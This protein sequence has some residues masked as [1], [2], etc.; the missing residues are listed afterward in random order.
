MPPLDSYLKSCNARL[1]HIV[2]AKYFNLVLYS[3]KDARVMPNDPISMVLFAIPYQTYDINSI[4]NGISK[5][6]NDTELEEALVNLFQLNKPVPLPC[7]ELA[8]IVFTHPNSSRNTNVIHNI[9]VSIFRAFIHIVYHFPK[10]L[11]H[12]IKK[13]KYIYIPPLAWQYMS[14]FLNFFTKEMDEGF[15]D[16]LVLV[17]VFYD[18]MKQYLP[19]ILSFEDSHPIKK[20]LL[21]IIPDVIVSYQREVS[22]S[23]SQS[24]RFINSF[25]ISMTS[26][27]GNEVKPHFCTFGVYSSSW[28]SFFEA[29]NEDEKNEVFTVCNS[30]LSMFDGLHDHIDK[31]FYQLGY[32]FF[33]FLLKYM[34]II[35]VDSIP[36]MTGFI[37]WSILMYP[38]TFIAFDDLISERSFSEE[39]YDMKSVVDFYSIEEYRKEFFLVTR[40]EE[41]IALKSIDE[42]SQIQDK[43]P[44]FIVGCSKTP[45][46]SIK[47]AESLVKEI[48]TIME[49]P[50]K[51]VFLCYTI[52]LLSKLNDFCVASAIGDHWNLFF[53]QVI[54]GNPIQVYKSRPTQLFVEHM[55][56]YLVYFCSK[57][58]IGNKNSR[59][60]IL[61]AISAFYHHSNYS[62]VQSL[63]LFFHTLMF[64]DECKFPD[65]IADSHLLKQLALFVD[66]NRF[67][68]IGRSLFQ[69]IQ[70][71]ILM[72]PIRLLSEIQFCEIWAKLCSHRPFHLSI[73]RLYK[74]LLLNTSHKHYNAIIVAVMNNINEV[75]KNTLD[76]KGEYHELTNSLA[77]MISEIINTLLIEP[78]YDILYKNILFSFS[79]IPTIIKDD[80]L[81]CICMTLVRKAFLRFPSLQQLIKTKGSRIITNITASIQSNNISNHVLSELTSILLSR[82]VNFGDF[83]IIKNKYII[84]AILNSVKNTEMEIQV[85]DYLLF[86]ITE[87]RTNALLCSEGGLFSLSISR[88]ADVED[89]ESELIKSLLLIITSIFEQFPSSTFLLQMFPA[90]KKGISKPEFLWPKSLLHFFVRLSG[91][92]NRDNHHPFISFVGPLSGIVGPQISSQFLPEEFTL[93]MNIRIPDRTECFSPL[94]LFSIFGD[95]SHSISI[96]LK[97]SK[98]GIVFIN[99]MESNLFTFSY[100]F[101]S[102][103]WFFIQLVFGQKELVLYVQEQF[104]EQVNRPRIEWP[105]NIQ[106]KVG[107]FND[108][109]ITKRA[110]GEFRD[111]F[112]LTGAQHG[113][114]SHDITVENMPQHIKKLSICSYNLENPNGR[115]IALVSPNCSAIEYD[116]IFVPR[117]SEFASFFGEEKLWESLFLLFF[118]AAT[119]SSEGDSEENVV[120]LLPQIINCIC[121][122]NSKSIDTL[123]S[124][125]GVK[126]ISNRLITIHP[127][128][129]TTQFFDELFCLMLDFSNDDFRSSLL[130]YIFLNINIVKRLQSESLLHYAH[131]LLPESATLSSHL[132]SKLLSNS[133]LVEYILGLS[134]IPSLPTASS[135][136]VIATILE[137]IMPSLNSDLCSSILQLLLSQIKEHIVFLLLRFIEDLLKEKRLELI[138]SLSTVSTFSP[139]IQLLYNHP[140]EIQRLSLRCMQL[141]GVINDNN[142]SSLLSTLLNFVYTYDCTKKSTNELFIDSF[143]HIFGLYGSSSSLG[144]HPHDQS[145]PFYSPLIQYPVRSYEFF[146]LMVFFAQNAKD[147]IVKLAFKEFGQYTSTN[148]ESSHLLQKIPYWVYWVYLFCQKGIENTNCMTSFLSLLNNVL[149]F[150]YK[151]TGFNEIS[152]CLSMLSRLGLYYS[153]DVTN[154]QKYVILQTLAYC[155]SNF[156]ES[157]RAKFIYSSSFIL[158]FLHPISIEPSYGDTFVEISPQYSI[159]MFDEAN[160]S[161]I[162]QGKDLISFGVRSDQRSGSIEY[163]DLDLSSLIINSMGSWLE[164][165]SSIEIKFQDSISYPSFIVF[166]YFC[167]CHIRSSPQSANLILTIYT[168]TLK[169]VSTLLDEFVLHSASGIVLRALHLIN[170]P[171]DSKYDICQYHYDH[172]TDNNDSPSLQCFL[173]E[174][175][176][177][178]NKNQIFLSLSTLA[179]C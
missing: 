168:E 14:Y 31:D 22:L 128:F 106:L 162:I 104:E 18:A 66:H 70:V 157:P 141:I 32:R 3:E 160:K 109:K 113:I 107:S 78:F 29:F 176:I 37:K 152:N 16:F 156:E 94:P 119:N 155:P 72:E 147:E 71:L 11:Y 59:N 132:F 55:R 35:N 58:Y 146:P 68:L 116:G 84:P 97:E 19:T 125:D 164:F 122:R 89:P 95:D 44:D 159:K 112:L 166:S 143:D 30:V 82:Q 169:K 26:K 96:M 139:F 99:R 67:T 10:E 173:F 93:S 47:L 85:Y 4:R 142:D 38:I 103:Q 149:K 163:I 21:S 52:V 114:I 137:T 150:S 120:V 24:F 64:S 34:G 131:N 28:N 83:G 1:D 12:A 61:E 133:R 115:T 167:Y 158:L 170:Y 98:L 138:N 69:L 124:I 50:A 20:M 92:E 23:L 86:L 51:Q 110:V 53:D 175:N 60:N 151:N 54:F 117:P 174:E 148:P 17:K 41:P 154:I 74:D 80:Q 171:S 135:E 153:V 48:S 15:G 8:R 62:F 25:I 161:L 40:T 111:V 129:L 179:N 90:I 101:D 130:E 9:S 121:N 43:I 81:L 118:S 108:T 165:N 91:K 127:R 6:R 88:I 145:Q 46:F 134:E 5:C 177:N 33:D 87:N 178:A 7:F 79:S 126:T 45:A 42:L 2:W 36:H 56:L 136:K 100:V 73:V 76:K 105:Q 13:E 75:F 65:D 27:P 77:L 63:M 144:N 39:D 140:M 49:I 102:D 57:A 123:I 172:F